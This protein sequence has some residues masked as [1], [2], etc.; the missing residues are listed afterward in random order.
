MKMEQRGHMPYK[1]AIQIVGD[2]YN[3]LHIDAGPS[4][5]YICTQ[6]HTIQNHLATPSP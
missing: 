3:H 2:M 4:T 5:V 1:M 6:R